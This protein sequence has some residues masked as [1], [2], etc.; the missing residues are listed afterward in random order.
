MKPPSF[1]KENYPKG[2]T[3]HPSYFVVTRPKIAFDNRMEEISVSTP[4][5]GFPRSFQDEN[6]AY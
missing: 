6:P 3:R 1:G 4:V 5:S 2:Q